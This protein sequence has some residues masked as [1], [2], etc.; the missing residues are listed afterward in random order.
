[1]NEK[2]RAATAQLIKSERSA[3]KFLT[4]V[5]KA[6][7]I[8]SGLCFVVFIALKLIFNP[9]I[10]FITV[11]LPLIYYVLLFF[12]YK[13]FFL[14]RYKKSTDQECTVISLRTDPNISW[15]LR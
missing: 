5:L 4:S 1:M 7:G 9:D 14:I 6:M 13:L 10:S 2:E 11:F 8:F 3:Y 15:I 12:L